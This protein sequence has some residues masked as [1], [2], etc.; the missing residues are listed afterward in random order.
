MGL[1][2]YEDKEYT[3]KVTEIS[4]LAVKETKTLYAKYEVTQTDVDNQ[5]KLSNIATAKDEPSDPAETEVEEA[6]PGYNIEKTATLEDTSKDKAE[7]G[8]TIRYIIIVENT[9]NVTL[10][11]IVITDT[12][13]NKSATV[14]TLNIN[15]GK[16][17]VLEFTHVVEES[18][19]TEVDGNF[20]VKNIVISE[21]PDPTDE[22]KTITDEDHAEVPV[23]ENYSYIVNYYTKDS[24]DS[25]YEFKESSD[26]IEARLGTIINNED[27]SAENNRYTGYKLE[28]IENTPLT[29]KAN[30]AENVINVYYIKDDTQTKTLSY[31]VEYYKDNELV[32]GDTLSYTKTVWINDPDTLEVEDVDTSDDR[33]DGY[34]FDYTNPAEIPTEIENEGVI[35]VYYSSIDVT[36]TKTAVNQNGREMDPLHQYQEGDTVYYKLTATNN[37]NKTIK[38]YT[39]TDELPE[40]LG[41][42]TIV[43]D[44]TNLAPGQTAN[45]TISAVIQEDKWT[46]DPEDTYHTISTTNIPDSNLTPMTYRQ[47]IRNENTYNT[48]SSIINCSFHVYNMVDGEVPHEDGTTQYSAN[49]YTHVG[50]GRVDT[51]NYNTE[52]NSI[53]DLNTVIDTHNETVKTIIWAPDYTPENGKVVLWYVSKHIPENEETIGSTT[54]YVKYHVD[55]VLVDLNKVFAITNTIVGSNGATSTVTTKASDMIIAKDDGSFAT[56]SNLNLTSRKLLVNTSNIITEQETDNVTEQT[57]KIESVIVK[58]EE[59]SVIPVESEKIKSEISK[60]EEEKVEKAEKVENEKDRKEDKI[61]INN[62]KKD[63]ETEKINKTIEED[64]EKNENKNTSETILNYEDKEIKTMDE[65]ENPTIEKT[66]VKA[67]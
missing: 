60:V 9:G 14:K 66:D 59:K 13:M 48:N 56:K 35:K 43:W 46:S 52:L 62:N 8:D 44:I 61:T 22:T 4:E 37:G 38:N 53:E 1:D 55:G 67:E 36:L 64:A 30:E 29:I 49:N 50:F 11:D 40:E 3:T 12:T 34:V 63:E 51:I 26:R 2:V 42:E 54:A 16:I 57:D 10:H 15:S 6:T 7:I 19:I 23:K 5:V 21:C 39:V 32:E 18:D 45:K 24:N 28:K 31:T 47:Y 41:G 25:D 58:S 20:V 33:Y 65:K 27:I 17:K